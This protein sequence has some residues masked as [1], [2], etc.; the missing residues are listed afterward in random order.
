VAV[1]SNYFASCW[2]C[3]GCK[4]GLL[5]VRL[6]KCPA[7]SGLDLNTTFHIRLSDY[8]LSIPNRYKTYHIARAPVNTALYTAAQ[9]P[10][11]CEIRMFIYVVTKGS[12]DRV[13]FCNSYALDLYSGSVRF[14]SEPEHRKSWLIFLVV[15]LS[16][17]MKNFGI[18][19][20]LIR[21]RPL[22]SKSFL[23]ER[24]WFRHYA[25]N[26]KVAGSIPD[27][28]TGFFIWTNPS[29]R[30]MA[31]GSTQRLT[32]MSTRKILGG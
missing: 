11:C 22:P 32:E 27:E 18:V 6:C 1:G 15:F 2:L 8:R 17:S 20:P 4:H 14:K 16:Y 30:T 7:N 25:T 21:S 13:G 23:K 31:L 29:S 10:S 12:S 28:V 24:S 19:P 3:G 5:A 26:R 9:W